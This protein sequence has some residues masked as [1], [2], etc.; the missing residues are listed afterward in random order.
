MYTMAPICDSGAAVDSLGAVVHS[1]HLAGAAL[2]PGA[3]LVCGGRGVGWV[4]GVGRPRGTLLQY[5]SKHYYFTNL[6]SNNTL[7]Y[8]N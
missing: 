8:T 2:L 7:L 3:V 6:Y 1:C 4:G 5:S